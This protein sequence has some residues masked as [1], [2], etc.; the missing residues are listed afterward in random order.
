MSAAENTRRDA[1]DLSWQE[2]CL[3]DRAYSTAWARRQDDAAAEA[4][5]WA[6]VLKQKQPTAHHR[7]TEGS[8]RKNNTD[9]SLCVSVCES[10]SEVA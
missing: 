3:F 4:A 5:A 9:A 8:E 1:A 10:F 7:D 6:A 2:R